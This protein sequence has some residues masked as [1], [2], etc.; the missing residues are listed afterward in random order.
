MKE[1]EVKILNVSHKNLEP[2][3]LKL[4][5][6]K[7]FDKEFDVIY[8]DNPKGDLKR[9]NETLRLR[10]EGDVSILT[11]KKRIPNESVKIADETEIE[12]SDFKITRDLILK[13]GFQESGKQKKRRISYKLNNI[14][15]EFDIFH[16][17]YEFVP[18]FLEIESDN[19]EDIY[20]YANLLGFTKE[21]CK[22]WNVKEL[23]RYY[24]K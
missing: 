13:L 4:G 22:P 12:V 8:F 17:P 19:I 1:V 23:I 21:D 5:A 10:K 11:Y 18:E 14:K 2:K 3:L 24:S 7:L 16:E 9:L 6:K 15:L 20:K